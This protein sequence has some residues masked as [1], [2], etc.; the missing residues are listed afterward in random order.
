[1]ALEELR[2]AVGELSR[3]RIRLHC[4]QCGSPVSKPI[5]ETLETTTHPNS[6][7]QYAWLYRVGCEAS[8]R[9]QSRTDPEIGVLT[10]K[11]RDLDGSVLPLEHHP[12]RIGCCG[13]P[14]GTE[15]NIKCHGCGHWILVDIED[16]QAPAMTAARTKE[17][18]LRPA[19]NEEP[20]R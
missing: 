20:H 2:M 18:E 1:M 13:F 14:G 19:P 16:C 9:G 8:L 15:P 11:R 3:Q 6:P 5:R 7:G 12:D 4:R 10:L 17:I